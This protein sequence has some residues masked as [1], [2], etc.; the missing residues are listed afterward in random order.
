MIIDK[1]ENRASYYCL[2][3][4][5]KTALDYFAAYDGKGAIREDVPLN[6]STF[7]KIRPMMTKKPEDASFEAHNEYA[8]IHFLADGIE[9]IG[10]AHR[11]DLKEISSN[12][13]KD[14]VTLDGEGQY[15]TLYKGW[16]MITLPQDAHK[17]AVAY[18]REQSQ[19]IKLIAKVKV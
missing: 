2:G 12:P 16:F 17:P 7:V 1:I 4:E 13:E 18:N 10:Y 3:E 15:L 14:M 19:I 6:E 8:D 9:D 5:F 11:N